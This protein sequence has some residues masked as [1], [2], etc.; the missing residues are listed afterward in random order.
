VD[1]TIEAG[2]TVTDVLTEGGRRV[3]L[4]ELRCDT[5]AGVR[6]LAGTARA[7]LD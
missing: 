3:A 5:D 4:L 2:A 7:W 6:V 1:E